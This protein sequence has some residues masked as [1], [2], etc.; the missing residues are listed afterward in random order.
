M[1]LP[2]VLDISLLS[3]S[4]SVL[5]LSHCLFSLNKTR[6]TPSHPQPITPSHCLLSSLLSFSLAQWRKVSRL[7]DLGRSGLRRSGPTRLCDLGLRDEVCRS[8]LRGGL[9][10]EAS[11]IWG[12]ATRRFVGLWGLLGLWFFAVMV[13]VGLLGLR[14]LLGLWF[15]CCD[16]GFV[17]FLWWFAVD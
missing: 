12:F 14:G 15:F 2:R 6:A 10:E 9:R 5:S 11:P 4:A 3:F 13:F 17:V 7:R 8:R 16:G 1:R